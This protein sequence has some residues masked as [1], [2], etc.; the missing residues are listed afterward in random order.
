MGANASTESNDN[1]TIITYNTKISFYSKYKCNKLINY[2]SNF[3]D[4]KTI[5]CLQGIND[6]KSKDDIIKN[7]APLFSDD[8]I[9]SS[10]KNIVEVK[11]FLIITNLNVKSVDYKEFNIDD[12]VFEYNKKAVLMSD[13]DH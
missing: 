7:I 8:G 3:K 6:E 4:K 11:D 13:I 2:L 9:I 12:N 1:I 10:K 5:I